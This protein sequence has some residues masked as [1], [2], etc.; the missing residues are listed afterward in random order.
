MQEK[1][2]MQM[3]KQKDSDNSSGSWSDLWGKP[4][5]YQST[6]A[7]LRGKTKYFLKK[8]SKVFSLWD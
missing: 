6:G 8:G 1:A 7:L 5:D 4:K 2:R 3:M